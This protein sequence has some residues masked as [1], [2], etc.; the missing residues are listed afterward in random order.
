MATP[1]PVMRAAEARETPERHAWAFEV[2]A[3]VARYGGKQVL[4][5]DELCCPA[6][7]V[8]T[9]VGPSG[10]GKS[11]LLKLLANLPEPS[12]ESSGTIHDFGRE[13]PAAAP[14]DRASSVAAHYAMVWQTPLLFPCSILENLSLPLRKRH[15]PRREWR[16]RVEESLA[17]VGLLQELGPSWG[18]VHGHQISVGQRQRACLARSLLQESRVILL[19]EPCASLDPVSTDKIEGV[20]TDLARTRAVVLVTHNLGQARR[21]SRYAAVFCVGERGGYVCENGPAQE[22][23]HDPQTIEGRSFLLREIGS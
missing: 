4:R 7:G 5:V 15:I 21:V 2:E 8:T 6:V 3:L 1:E 22:C 10:C 20:I 17:A 9:L 14:D 18:E 16:E 12:L 19:D 13:R 23:L 11:T